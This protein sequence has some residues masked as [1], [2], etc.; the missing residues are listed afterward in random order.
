MA[1]QQRGLLDFGGAIVQVVQ[2]GLGTNSTFV[3]NMQS[4][5]EWNVGVHWLLQSVSENRAERIRGI[6]VEPVQEYVEALREGVG[7][8]KMPNVAL[9]CAA[10]GRPVHGCAVV[11][12]HVLTQKHCDELMKQADD[13]L[14]VSLQVSLE[15]VIKDQGKLDELIRQAAQHQREEL[16][17]HFAYIRNMS[18]VN[19]E[20]PEFQSLQRWLRERRSITVELDCRSV[21]MWSWGH[22]CKQLNFRGCELLIIDTEG[23]DATILRSMIDHCAWQEYRYND[24]VWPHVIQF[25]TMG[26]CDQLEGWSSEWAV[27]SELQYYGYTLV[28]YSHHDSHLARTEVLNKKERVWTWAANS[29]RCIQCRHT[30]RWPYIT[31][32]E[33]TVYC[34]GC[35]YRG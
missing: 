18:C 17:W 25:E 8:T 21:A 4:V 34:R 33:K 20:H 24:N 12:L 3:Q 19:S 11:N 23:H 10:L 30:C 32:E 13:K 35:L 31:T 5:E 29:Y 6:A 26:H 14:R 16:L 9:V 15:K 2:A 22:L 7:S 28:H 27:I 1:A